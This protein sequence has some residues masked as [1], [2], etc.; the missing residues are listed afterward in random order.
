MDTLFKSELG[1]SLEAAP[2]Q[3]VYI[4]A[5]LTAAER[6]RLER[7]T[8]SGVFTRIY[9]GLYINADGGTAGAFVLGAH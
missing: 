8:Q 1:N 5:Q 7:L 9:K 4:A 6:K 2:S 3:D